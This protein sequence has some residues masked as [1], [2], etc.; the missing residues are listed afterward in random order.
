MFCPFWHKGKK[1]ISQSQS[2]GFVFLVTGSVN[3]EQVM[4]WK[5]TCDLTI[6]NTEHGIVVLKFWDHLDNPI[7]NKNE[8]ACFLP[9]KNV[10][11]LHQKPKKHTD[12]SSSMI[13]MH[14]SNRRQ[15]WS[16]QWLCRNAKESLAQSTFR[17]GSCLCLH[18]F[19]IVHS[20]LACH[21]YIYS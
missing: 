6:Y 15:W 2:F 12:V 16:R 11:W 13:L 9:Q 14:S 5:V 10:L 18:A 1:L 21:E 7:Y 19:H 17:T 3:H 8:T 4:V 20:T